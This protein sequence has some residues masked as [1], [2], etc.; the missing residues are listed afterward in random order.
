EVADVARTRLL[1]VVQSAR[2]SVGSREAYWPD[3]EVST[4][5][6]APIVHALHCERPFQSAPEKP[7]RTRASNLLEMACGLLEC[8][9]CVS[10]GSW[11]CWPLRWRAPR[12]ISRPHRSMSNP[13]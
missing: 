13:P 6:V 3:L 12:D 5:V 9:A 10:S 2:P 1:V 8:A 11:D 7:G 4:P